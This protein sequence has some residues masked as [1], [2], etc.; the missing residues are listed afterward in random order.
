MQYGLYFIADDMYNKK[1]RLTMFSMMPS[2]NIQNNQNAYY[3]PEAQF[4][5]DYKS[6]QEPSDNV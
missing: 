1:V 4:L 5:V 3:S 6:L 2:I